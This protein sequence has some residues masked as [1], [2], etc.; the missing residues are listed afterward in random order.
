VVLVAQRQERAAALI[1]DVISEL[2][3]RRLKDP[4][5]GFVS[6]VNVEVSRDLSLARIYVSVYGPEEDKEKTM[7]GLKSAQGL[8][9]SEVSKVLGTRHVPEIQFVLDKG[10]EHSIK[11]SRLLSEIRKDEVSGQESKMDK[12]EVKE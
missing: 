11:V 1:R 7:E 2:I 12:E 10:I 8:V 6:V 4:R 3:M 9:R 5:I